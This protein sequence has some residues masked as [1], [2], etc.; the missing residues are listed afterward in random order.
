M[1]T[2]PQVSRSL[3]FYC[4]TLAALG[5]AVLAAS[6]LLLPPPI[7]PVFVILVL[8]SLVAEYL[9]VEIPGVGSTS[10]SYSL[11]M[12][13]MLLF[14]PAAAGT[15]SLLSAPDWRDLRHSRPSVFLAMNAGQMT[16]SA[17]VAGWVYLIA[18][19][20]T[21]VLVTD[22]GWVYR[23][24][25]AADFPSILIP[26]VLSAVVS[27]GLNDL[28]VSYAIHVYTSTPWKRLLSDEVV[29]MA[30]RQ[31]ALAAVGFSL[32]EALAIS[33]PAFVLFLVPLVVARQ[34]FRHSLTLRAAYVDTVRGLVNAVEAKDPYT[35]GHSE[36]VSRYASRLG[37][38]AALTP[39]QL[40][41]LEYAAL[42]HDI[43]K[44][45]IPISVLNKPARL[46]NEEYALIQQHPRIGAQIV[47]KVPYLESIVDVVL[48]HHEHYDGRGYGE[49]VSQEDIPVL[50]RV[51]SV[52]DACDA[53]TSERPYRPALTPQ[54]ASD[55]VS[56]CA[57][58]QFDPQLAVLFTELVASGDSAL[59][60]DAS[61]DAGGAHRE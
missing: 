38:A 6:W 24:F 37:E 19:G 54:Q 33:R 16:L 46:T 12:S 13:T 42:L 3:A 59:L 48:F 9:A 47:S 31:L 32:A 56:R 34:V 29:W 2:S 53:M 21:L 23:P 44:I 1:D 28:L 49:G 41:N 60:P 18:G 20:R 55:E 11:S 14:G 22:G 45:G 26:L 5:I 27:V 8:A 58:T 36:R 57:G 25:T 10:L 17:C 50:A 39:R 15:S 4:W 51:M 61:Q 43:G 30:P 7:T 52:A 35:R 40:D